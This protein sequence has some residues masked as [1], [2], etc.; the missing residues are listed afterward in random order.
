MQYSNTSNI[1][2]SLAVF[3]ATDDYDYQPNTI[4]V[5]TL[6][7][8][9]KQI[10]LGKRLEKEDRFTDI[11]GLVASRMGSAIHTAIEKA[12]ANPTK[13]LKSLGYP[14]KVLDNIIINPT[15]EQIKPDSIPVYME[16]RTSKSIM[17]YTIT[18][19]YDFI[20]DGRVED[21]KSTV[22]YSYLNQTKKDD[23]ILQGSL[24]R[25]LNPDIIIKDEM[26]IN[27]IFTD[28]NKLESIKNK[29]YPPN[30]VHTQTLPLKSIRE[31]E[32]YV[33]NKLTQIKQYE[34]SPESEIPACTDKELWRKPT[35]WKYYKNLNKRERSTANFDNLLDATI[36]YNEDGAVGV[37]V[38]TK[39]QIMA[40]KYCPAFS[41]C[42][43]KDAYIE[44][45]ELVL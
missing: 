38:E 12:W 23:Y 43:Q 36:R 7:K 31:T 8:P 26:R 15:P 45:G 44:S 11:S 16:Q 22:V 17:G 21:F 30:R 37:I 42:Q 24:Y 2:L 14:N 32:Q 5:T 10:I 41:I 34:N 40:C 28:W 4:S 6:L 33:R 18:G 13:A 25:W 29:N 3:L 35:V 39:G 19:K 1:P 20:A 27:Y 9:I